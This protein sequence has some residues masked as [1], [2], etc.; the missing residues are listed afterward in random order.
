[1]AQLFSNNVDTQL[2]AP[3]TDVGTSAT[4]ADGSGLNTPTGGDFELLTLIDGTTVEIVRMTARTGN[5]VTIT[6]AQEGTTAV[7]WGT[8]ARV[9]SGITA[10]SLDRKPENLSDQATTINL[11][12]EQGASVTNSVIIGTG[13]TAAAST[14]GSVIIGRIAESVASNVVAIGNWAEPYAAGAIAVGASSYTHTDASSG[15][16][17]GASSTTYGEGS[18][19]I[20]GGANSNNTAAISIGYNAYSMGDDT[21]AIGQDATVESSA[22]GAIVLGGLYVFGTPNVFAAKALPVVPKGGTEANAAFE[23]AGSQSV[24]M[25]GVLDFKN[26]QTYTIPVPSGVTFFPDEVGVIVTAASGV[27]GQPTLQFGVTGTADKYLAASATVGLAAVGDRERFATLASDAGATT[28]RAEVTVV[29]TGTTLSGR[30]YWKG[31]AVI[32]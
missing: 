20:G 4:L 32:D 28:L 3:L 15:V 16:A 18:I 5:T 7:A 30:V 24:V 12:G 31:M 9:F 10:G 6:R 17:I 21:I 22:E 13:A 8:G 27:S 14:S 25:S 11:L 1:M 26:L 29:A 19:S 2:S 23:M